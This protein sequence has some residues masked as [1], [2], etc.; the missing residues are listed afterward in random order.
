MPKTL[1]AFWASSL[2]PYPD[3]RMNCARDTEARMPD[4]FISAVKRAPTVL[5][6]SPSDSPASTLACVPEVLTGVSEEVPSCAV[7]LFARSPMRAYIQL[8][9]QDLLANQRCTVRIISSDFG[10]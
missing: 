3:S 6:T 1:L 7:T 5:I 10:E 9:G 2:F 4:L 8:P